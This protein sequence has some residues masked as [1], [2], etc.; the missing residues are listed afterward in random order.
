MLGAVSRASLLSRRDSKESSSQNENSS[1][2]FERMHSSE[3][4]WSSNPLAV[5]NCL[6]SPLRRYLLFK[7]RLRVPF[8]LY[9]LFFAPLRP[10]ASLREA[11][12][13]GSSREIF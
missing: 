3:S 12:R 5:S 2:R 8:G 13:A 1:S 4:L 7:I 10:P 11:L 9:L 6:P